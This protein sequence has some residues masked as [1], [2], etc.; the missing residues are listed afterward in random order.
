MLFGTD[1]FLIVLP[2][3]S[4]SRNTPCSLSPFRILN[5]RILQTSSRTPRIADRHVTRPK[6]TQDNTNWIKAWRYAPLDWG[7][8]PRS[9]CL[10]MWSHWV[11]WAT[12][13]L[14]RPVA[15]FSPKTLQWTPKSLLTY[16]DSPCYTFAYATGVPI[17]HVVC[18]CMTQRRMSGD[19][20]N[21]ALERTEGKTSLGL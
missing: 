3:P 19:P 18:V 1:C 12:R 14:W 10:R 15:F 7:S 20:A 6:L 4:L 16:T 8:N 13:L 11:P 9:Q 21:D 2:M 5:L 17:R